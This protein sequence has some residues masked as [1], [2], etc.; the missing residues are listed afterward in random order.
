MKVLGRLIV[1]YLSILNPHKLNCNNVLPAG[2]LVS[3][4]WRNILIVSNTYSLTMNTRSYSQTET[5]F[6]T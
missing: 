6:P 5:H 1:I 3:V 2:L 4:E